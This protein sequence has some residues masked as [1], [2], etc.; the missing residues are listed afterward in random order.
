MYSKYPKGTLEWWILDNDGGDE[1]KLLE[2]Q[3]GVVK[4]KHLDG[5]EHSV[6]LKVVNHE[7]KDDEVTFNGVNTIEFEHK[8]NSKK[9]Q[10]SDIIIELP[11]RERFYAVRVFPHPLQAV[12]VDSSIAGGPIEALAA[13]MHSHSGL[14]VGRQ[15]GEQTENSIG[16]YIKDE[17]ETDLMK[18][19]TAQSIRN[20]MKRKEIHK[21]TKSE[22]EEAW[23]NL[24]VKAVPDESKHS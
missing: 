23:D 21:A 15:I 18:H 22:I 13:N 20:L 4:G 7:D 12:V 24:A 17:L 11:V 3:T 6:Y 9:D 8:W 5:E 10:Y 2:C 19:I 1:R 14:P 16:Y